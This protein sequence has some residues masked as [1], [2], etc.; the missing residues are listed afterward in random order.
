MVVWSEDLSENWYH[1]AITLAARILMS[2]V[3][4]GGDWKV[5]VIFR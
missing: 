2:A 1:A 4:C 5:G 3:E